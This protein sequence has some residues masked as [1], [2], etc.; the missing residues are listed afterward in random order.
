MN[1]DINDD[2]QRLKGLDLVDQL[3]TKLRSSRLVPIFQTEER[4]EYIQTSSSKEA[5]ADKH[6]RE[7][8]SAKPGSVKRTPPTQSLKESHVVS[9][10]SSSGDRPRGATQMHD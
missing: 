10:R 8:A 7:N 4:K 2:S 5:R 3:K 6:Y 1:G 9:S